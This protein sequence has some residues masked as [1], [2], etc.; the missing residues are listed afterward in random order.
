LTEYFGS[1]AL[2]RKQPAIVRQIGQVEAP[3]RSDIKLKRISLE[4]T[5]APAVTSQVKMRTIRRTLARQRLKLLMGIILIVF[6]VTGI[7]AVVVYRQA[8][9]LEMNFD[10]LAAERKINKI[11]QTCGQISESLA[12]KT[13]LDLIRQQ[14][15][16]KLGLQDP[17]RSQI[18]TVSIPNSDRVV[19]ASPATLDP[20]DESYLADVFSSIEGY[21]RTIGQK[22]QVD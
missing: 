19:F 2:K 12:Q 6:I 3:R 5:P 16:N 18:I 17:A 22:R 1:L 4:A 8:M 15:I 10:N 21:F 7:F 11:G 9:I 13:N 14:A 20:D